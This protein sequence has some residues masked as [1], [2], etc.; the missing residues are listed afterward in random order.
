MP[1]TLS[2]YDPIFYAQEALIVLHKA[3]GMAGRV[4]RGYDKNPQEL[5]SVIQ[6]RKPSTFVAQDAPGADIDITASSVSITLSKWKE[7]KFALTDKELSFTGERIIRDHITPAAYAL[8]DVVDSDLCA[9]YKDIP[10]FVDTTA[11][12]A[13]GDISS[14]FQKLFDNRVPTTDGQLHFMVNGQI[15]KELQDLT[16][17]HSAQVAGQG[18]NTDTLMRG[19]L[20]NRL[21]FE[22]FAN[23]NVATHVAGTSSDTALQ[24]LGAFAAGVSVIALDA[25]DAA[26]TGTLVAGDTFVIAGNTQRYAVTAL[27]T[28][29]GNAFATVNI[30]PPLAAAVVDNTAVTLRQSS[31]T[32]S[33]AFHTNAFALATAP[34][35]DMG[36]AV[37]ARIATVSD[38]ITGLTLRSRLWYD[39]NNSKVK[40][41]LDILY[42]YTTL[43]ANLAVNFCD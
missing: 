33:M 40:V 28:A 22:F 41:G 5:G 11:P 16:L 39:G 15:Q 9:L 1:N 34:L 4:H 18:N 19:S 38:P 6:I 14:V 35:S 30:I 43:D 12:V 3:L 8:A 21:G 37:G 2:I 42:G 7:V 31:T 13:L 36:N 26:V 27:S 20:G 17:F 23:Q 32:R 25:V 29:A 10:W 24:I